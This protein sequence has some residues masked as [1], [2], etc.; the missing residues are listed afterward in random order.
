MQFN[1]SNL[2]IFF[3]I[4]SERDRAKENNN[5]GNSICTKFSSISCF[6]L[7]TIQAIMRKISLE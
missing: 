3:S 7:C 2:S 6:E 1:I 5:N 4:E